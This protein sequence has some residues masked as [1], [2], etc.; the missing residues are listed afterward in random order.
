MGEHDLRT[1]KEQ[2]K[3]VLAPTELRNRLWNQ[4]NSDRAETRRPAC[5]N[6]PAGEPKTCS[7][8]NKRTQKRAKSYLAQTKTQQSDKPIRTEKTREKVSAL[9]HFTVEETRGNKGTGS[10]AN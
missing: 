4:R 1:E 3:S 5:D 7:G 9:M 6:K 2:Q 8:C 10:S